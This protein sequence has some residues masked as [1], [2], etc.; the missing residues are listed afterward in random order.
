MCI[1]VDNKILD[2]YIWGNL[3]GVSLLKVFI[4]IGWG[5]ALQYLGGNLVAVW[6]K[7]AKPSLIPPPPHQK[8][9]LHCPSHQKNC[10]TAPSPHLCYSCL[11]APGQFLRVFPFFYL[12]FSNV[13]L[14]GQYF[15]H[16]EIRKYHH[17]LFIFKFCLQNE[18]YL[19][20][21]SCNPHSTLA[22]ETRTSPKYAGGERLGRCWQK[23]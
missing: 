11:P 14:G 2:I 3:V 19:V 18:R 8:K 17:F 12:F 20:Q 22:L 9:S 6:R 15:F 21:A 4:I 23:C 10:P 5:N 16:I 13:F 1:Y 7:C